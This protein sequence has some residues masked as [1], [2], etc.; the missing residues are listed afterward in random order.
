MTTGLEAQGRTQARAQ[1]LPSRE[2][3]DLSKA[4]QQKPQKKDH[5]GS[6]AKRKLEGFG[7][8]SELGTGIGGLRVQ[9][10]RFR[11]YGVRI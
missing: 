5:T 4:R 11:A 1:Q 3:Q 2:L 6:E 9:G 7:L 10:S 8:G